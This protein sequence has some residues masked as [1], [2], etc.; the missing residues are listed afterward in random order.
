MKY[1]IITLMG[2]FCAL[3]NESELISIPLIFNTLIYII[4][5]IFV[6]INFLS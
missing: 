5:I 1:K 4:V 2:L 3:Y 6:G